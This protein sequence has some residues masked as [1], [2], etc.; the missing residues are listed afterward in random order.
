MHAMLMLKK[1]RQED[2]WGLLVRQP[3]LTSELQTAFSK[4]KEMPQKCT[5]SEVPV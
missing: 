4:K 5:L 1:Q 2:P 3:E